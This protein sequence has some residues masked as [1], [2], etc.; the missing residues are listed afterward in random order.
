VEKIIVSK[1]KYY[2]GEDLICLGFSYFNINSLVKNGILKKINHTTF[3]NLKYDGEENDFYLAN[4]YV[5]SGVI[6]LLSAARYYNLTT[7]IPS[8]VSIAINR[9]SKITTLPKDRLQ[10]YYFSPKR[11]TEGKIKIQDGLNY[12]YIYD[13]EKTVIDILSYRNKIGVEE[14]SDILKN[15]LKKNDRNLNKLYKYAKDF[16]CEKILRTYLDVLL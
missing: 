2:K 13:I 11:L 4:A 14:T 8:A 10:L 3:E 9:K 5:N 12:F 6:C 7:Y 16:H 1:K 15:Y